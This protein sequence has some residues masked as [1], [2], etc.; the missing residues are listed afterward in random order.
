MKEKGRDGGFYDIW[1]EIK[2]RKE[3]KDC[4]GDERE[5]VRNLCTVLQKYAIGDYKEHYNGFGAISLLNLYTVFEFKGLDE[6]A[7]QN[8]VLMIVVFLVY[9]KMFKRERRMSLIIDEAWRLLGHNA[10]K[11][12]IGGIARRARK[13][14]GSLVVATQNYFDFSKEKS[15]TAADVL[16]SSDWRVMAGSDG[17]QDEYLKMILA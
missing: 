11:E 8:S 5:A 15:E 3:S 9:S 16:A 2:K 4:I 13:Y 17:G 10:M 1:C 7:L 14:R 12:F 6:E